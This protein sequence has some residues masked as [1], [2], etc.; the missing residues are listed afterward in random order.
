[1]SELK[2]DLL[3]L[4]GGPGGYAA[5]FLAGDMGM[6]VTL[7]DVEANPGGV[8]LYRGC[9]PSKALLHLAKLVHETEMASNWGLTFA[10]PQIDLDRM[11]TWKNEVVEKLT[12]GLG[13]LSSRR[14]VKYIRG[15]GTFKSSGQLEIAT[16]DGPQ[17]L[18]FAHAIVATGS[19]PTTLPFV[20]H[21]SERVLDSTSALDLKDIPERLLVIGGGY[22]GLEL[23]SVYAALGSKVTVVEMEDTLLP[24]ADA[25]LVRPLAKRMDAIMHD[26]WL[27]TRVTSVTDTG[28]DLKVTFEGGSTDEAFFDRALVS[29]GRRPNSKGLGLE[30]TKAVV[31]QH[32]FIEVDNQLRTADPRIFAIG[33]VVG[34]PMLAHKASHEGR[35]AVEVIAG[36]KVAF[37]PAGIPAVVFTDPEVAWAGLTENEAKAQG[38]QVEVAK[39]PWAASGR[40][41]TVGATDGIT[42]LIIDP[43]TERILGVGICGAGAGELIAEGM[44]AIEMGATAEDLKLTIHAHPTLSETVMES[45]EVFFGQSTHVYRPKRK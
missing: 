19:H 36:H 15:R 35:T 27:K 40:A 16:A 42:K 26:V 45:A 13:Q 41:L 14:K 23:G 31:N 2:T 17:T 30:A 6:D 10:P 7:V 5:A 29:I 8:C 1:M 37:E 3:V 32:G 28:R 24:G 39:F 12:G 44:L 11:R 25:D 38:I 34:Q 43:E 22:I 4:G 9:I 21:E 18:N 20:P 33:D